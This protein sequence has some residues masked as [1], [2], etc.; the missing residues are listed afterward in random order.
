VKSIG[1][2]VLNVLR[3]NLKLTACQKKKL[4]KF[5]VPLRALAERVS[6]ATKKR[7]LNQKGGFLVTLL[8]AL[9]PT[10]PL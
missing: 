1:E 7:L 10:N 5:K 6:I 4:R 3:D 9:L 8:I 2:C